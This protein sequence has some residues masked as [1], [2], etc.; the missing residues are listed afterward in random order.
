MA[1]PT[2]WSALN[3][4]NTA[5]MMKLMNRTESA[6]CVLQG[7]RD[8]RLTHLVRD[9]PVATRLSVILVVQIACQNFWDLCSGDCRAAFL[10]GVKFG[11]LPADHGLV[12][13]YMSAP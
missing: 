9:A 8:P 1:K 3:R 6:R 10:Q 12:K 7:F 11:E 13:L 5:T 2:A 4:S